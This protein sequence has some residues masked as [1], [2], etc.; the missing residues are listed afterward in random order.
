MVNEQEVHVSR[1]LEWVRVKITENLTLQGLG[2]IPGAW[3]ALRELLYFIEKYAVPNT[4]Y[5]I[6]LQKKYRK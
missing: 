6:L 1:E 4:V 5:N 2:F 3:E